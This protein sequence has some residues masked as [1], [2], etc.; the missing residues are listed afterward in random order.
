M[1]ALA[2]AR[3]RTLVTLLA[4]SGMLLLGV[5]WGW[6]AVTEPFPERVDTPICTPTLV[7]A[8]T[9]VY[10]DQV[11]VS[12]TN[13]GGREGLAGRVLTLLADA[14]FG[15]GETDNAPPDADVPYAQIW[16]LD[17]E[18]PAVRLVR[19]QLGQGAEI[20][21]RPSELPGVTVVVGDDFEKLTGKGKW[22]KSEED[23]QVCVPPDQPDDDA[24]VTP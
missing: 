1:A 8:G 2:L 15:R 17:P 24:G 22:T 14:G 16:T 21:E 10:P 5:A 18:N 12:V 4:L 7:P 3:L 11:L 6:G 9:K 20:V 19:G 23:S 13:A